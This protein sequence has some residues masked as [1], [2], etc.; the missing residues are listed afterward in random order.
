MSNECTLTTKDNPYN[1]FEQFNEWFM[2]DVEKGYN[3]CSVLARIVEFTDDM[4]QKE[5]DEEVERAV[6]EII[7]YDF[8]D[9]YKKVRRTSSTPPEEAK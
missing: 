7:K 9:I 3:T 8:T 2:F 4:T 1:P 6:D 5:R